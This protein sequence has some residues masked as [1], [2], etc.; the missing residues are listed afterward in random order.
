M[1][2]LINEHLKQQALSAL[3]RINQLE[4][5]VAELTIQRDAARTT[6]DVLREERSRAYT[7]AYQL[8]QRVA[9]LTGQPPGAQPSPPA[10]RQGDE[11]P[12]GQAQPATSPPG[13][14]PEP[15]QAA[16]L[17]AADKLYRQA[18][19]ERDVAR[20]KLA[21]TEA[22]LATCERTGAGFFDEL[23]RERLLRLAAEQSLAEEREACKRTCPAPRPS[24]P[25]TAPP[26]GVAWRGAQ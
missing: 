20:A 6:A 4:R 8:E 16:T 19:A 22:Q 18:A 21:L 9:A 1:N 10:A 2:R 11:Q 7:L 14:R 5:E 25:P 17:T 15:F 26:E 13:A 3:E 23:G 24:R 12:P